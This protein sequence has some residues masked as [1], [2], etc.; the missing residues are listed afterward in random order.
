MI[1]PVH[2]I[3]F[4]ENCNECARVRPYDAAE[5]AILKARWKM[6]GAYGPP[7]SVNEVGRKIVEWCKSGKERP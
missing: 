4:D 1:C 3:L 7:P 2:P 5:E 6:Q